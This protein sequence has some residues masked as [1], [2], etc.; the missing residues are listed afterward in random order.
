MTG[1]EG[2]VVPWFEA[3]LASPEFTIVALPAAFVLGLLAALTSCCTYPA[4]GAIAGYSAAA[5]EGRRR[6][7]VMAAVFFLLGTFL[8]LVAM[9]VVAGLVSQA[10]AGAIGRYWRIFAGLA[11]LGFG[12]AALRLLPFP[13]PKFASPGKP[14]SAVGPGWDAAVFGFVVGGAATACSVTCTP[15][16]A[17]ALGVTVVKGRGL[18]G[19]V[20]LA[21]FAA[22]H[23][24]PLAAALLGLSFGK[25]LV[26]AKGVVEGI[27]I[28][29][30]VLLVILGFYL[31]AT[32]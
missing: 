14:G 9:G 3:A 13:V 19:A 17:V 21:V 7:A 25:S 27:R 12:L 8:A 29:G 4:I 23:A 18:W 30:G 32:F 26:R 10:L 16:V 22:G 15:L 5:G 28:G 2:S 11:A 31:L 24:L 20:L 1:P 6:D